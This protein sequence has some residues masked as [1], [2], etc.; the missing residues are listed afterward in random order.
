VASAVVAVAGFDFDVSMARFS[1]EGFRVSVRTGES[2]LGR[3]FSH[4]I[5]FTKLA[6]L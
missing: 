1:G 2:L 3:G 4:D 5:D 6:R